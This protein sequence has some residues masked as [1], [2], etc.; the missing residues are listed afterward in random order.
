MQLFPARYRG[1]EIIFRDGSR[2]NRL[3]LIDKG[4]IRLTTP[5]GMTAELS[6]GD[7]FGA[8]ALL[9]GDPYTET[10][11]AISDVELWGLN[12]DDFEALMLKYPIIGMNLSRELSRR[13]MYRRVEQPAPTQ[14]KPTLAAAAV[15]QPQ[16][17]P[18]ASTIPPQRTTQPAPRRSAVPVVPRRR[19]YFESLALWYG[20]LTRG[21]KVRLALL[22]LLLAWILGIALPATVVNAL[23][24]SAVYTPP[25]EAPS[26]AIASASNS[27]AP[28]AIALASRSE[29]ERTPPP[30]ATYTPP[31]TETPIP[32]DTPTLTPTPTD[33]PVPTATPT[34]TPV[35]TA[36]PT[37]TPEPTPTPRPRN[38][39]V[40]AA[41]A[42]TETPK[43]QVQ[44]SL[45][46][47]RRLNACENRGK[48]NIYVQ[49]VDANGE[50]VNDVLGCTSS[51]GC[52]LAKCWTGNEPHKRM[53]SPPS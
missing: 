2:G 7:F 26:I 16:P 25:P 32:T 38:R 45:V 39:A 5:E 24:T 21:A 52:A 30:T 51:V 8:A 3:N 1:G 10:A 53:I 22:L 15:A 27:V 19:G 41:A 28:V 47:M 31:P 13:R 43:P 9:T 44:Y 49:I 23:Q 36:T 14:P 40:A 37:D 4:N 17:Q 12:R 11:L 42:P 35:P 34:D 20:G 46:E 50:G 6:D 48:H 29:E 33:T 18:V